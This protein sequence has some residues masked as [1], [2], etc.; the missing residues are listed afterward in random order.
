[1]QCSSWSWHALGF[2]GETRRSSLAFDLEGTTDLSLVKKGSGKSFIVICPLNSDHS[3]SYAFGKRSILFS[4]LEDLCRLHGY[5]QFQNGVSEVLMFLL[6]LLRRGRTQDQRIACLC[7]SHGHVVSGVPKPCVL[8]HCCTFWYLPHACW[9]KM[10][11]KKWAQHR[12][13]KCFLGP[14]LKEHQFL[15]CFVKAVQKTYRK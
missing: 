4:C 6:K 13:L 3:E 7:S 9:C 1:M 12:Y 10:Y 5:M 2:R 8:Q 15:E 11:S 14:P